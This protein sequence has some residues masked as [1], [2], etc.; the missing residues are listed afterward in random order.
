MRI[1]LVQ[2]KYPHGGSGKRQ[3]Y[4]PG[5]LMNLASRFMA[6][7]VETDFVDLNL[8]NYCWQRLRDAD[9]IGISVL[10]TPY[11]PVAVDLVREI[12]ANS[13]SLPI[14]IGGE[15]VARIKSKHFDEW[16]AGLNVTQIKNDDDIARACGIDPKD[17]PSVYRTS[18]VPM[19]E[20]E[21]WWAGDHL[22]LY[23]T[24]EFALFLSQGCEFNCSYCAADKAR[25][26]QYRDLAAL[27]DEI[28]FICDYLRGIGHYDLRMYVSNLDAFQTPKKFEECMKVIH[29][30]ATKHGI[31]LHVRAL[32][33]SRCTFRACREDTGL[34][35][36]LQS[37][38]LEIVGFGA[39]GADEE[40]WQRQNKRHNSLFEL[41]T[42]CRAM[43]EAGIT[44]ELLMVIGFADDGARALWR[45]LKY[46]FV[47]AFKGRIIRP[48]L[49]KSQ[50]PSARWPEDNPQ[51][52]SF[53]KNVRLL[54]NLDYA[55]LGSKWTHPDFWQR[56]AANF[57]YLAIICFLAPFGK[58]PTR[59][60]VP[61]SREFGRRFA[62]LI[63]NM[64]PFDR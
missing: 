23:L 47:G 43:E 39:D 4:L 13:I 26:E 42:V 46:S 55:M 48:Y 52:Q 27:A 60:L 22:R 57:V 6:V 54:I 28:A 51:V 32:A 14:L 35:K 36:R 30:I 21:R 62:M 59:P 45:D 58:C 12:R 31:T 24:S 56:W 18:M 17:L 9:V 1:T 2:P 37:Y 64:M 7:G 3:V 15:G 29:D 16:F 49:A 34:A 5:G 61:N 63:N 8:V 50:T 40:T 19:L 33:T 53:L 38:G 25:K 10:G 20:R 44:V 41:Q 11:I